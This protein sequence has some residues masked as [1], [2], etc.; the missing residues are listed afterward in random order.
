MTFASA[1]R[2]RA[3]AVALEAAQVAGEL[4]LGFLG[5]LDRTRIGTKSAARD[6]VTE[7]D[8]A[9]ERCLVERLRRAFPEHAIESEEEVRDARSER[10]NV[11]LVHLIEPETCE[12]VSGTRCS[13]GFRKIQHR[14]MGEPDVV[15]VRF[16]P[17]QRG[18]VREQGL[19]AAFELADAR[20]PGRRFGHSGYATRITSRGR[21]LF[22]AAR[23]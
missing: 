5:R 16:E 14:A 4:L 1:E 17:L 21:F 8:L 20:K 10:G 3:E 7:A 11:R 6:L 15:R 22:I 9:A 2:A 12:F 13:A 23:L 18:V 19:A